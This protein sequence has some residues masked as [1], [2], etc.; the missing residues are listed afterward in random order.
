MTLIAD[1]PI[2]DT[3]ILD[4]SQQ[5]IP[6]EPETLHMAQDRLDTEQNQPMETES[7]VNHPTTDELSHNEPMGE[8]K[9]VHEQEGLR[10]RIT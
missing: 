8:T 1:V 5:D 3:T 2:S 7:G 4:D 6:T 10:Q 9:S